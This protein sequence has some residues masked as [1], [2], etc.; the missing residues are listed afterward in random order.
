M[1]K[2]E[3]IRKLRTIYQYDNTAKHNLFSL[4][5]NSNHLGCVALIFFLD[6]LSL[7]E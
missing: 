7:M 3:K 2:N 1:S 5:I 6:V 4:Q